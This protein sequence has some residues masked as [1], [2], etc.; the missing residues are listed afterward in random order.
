MKTVL[1]AL[2]AAGVGL[3]LL[4][5][6]ALAHHRHHRHHRMSYHRT[7]YP[8]TTNTEGSYT[9]NGVRHTHPKNDADKASRS[10]NHEMNNMS[11]SINH[12]F[13]GKKPTPQGNR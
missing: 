13:Q 9:V 8:T 4:G 10:F 12:A 5:S 11:K 6:P 7:Y 1:T 3:S 2:V